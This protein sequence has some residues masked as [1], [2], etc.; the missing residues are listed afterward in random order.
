[1]A[2]NNEKKEAI[3]LLVLGLM[4]LPCLQKDIMLEASGLD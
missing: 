2:T 3:V 1:V 4:C